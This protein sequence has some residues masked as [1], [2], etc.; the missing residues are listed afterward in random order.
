MNKGKDK[1][2]IV[3]DER[4]IRLLVKGIFKK[5]Y[6]VI[7]ACNGKEAINIARTQKPDLILM[8]IMMPN[9]DGYMACHAI[10]SDPELR[11]I[12]I[13]MLTG[14]NYE[15]NKKLGRK[16]G[17]DSYLTKPFNLSELQNEVGKFL[18]ISSR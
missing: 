13:I 6:N 12:P 15:L 10:K 7:E 17:A 11:G 9:V 4:N 3:D 1:I 18:L 5:E 14:I 2:L 16:F 8:D